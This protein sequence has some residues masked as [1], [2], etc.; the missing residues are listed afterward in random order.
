MNDNDRWARER[1][2]ECASGN[3]ETSELE[4]TDGRGRATRERERERHSSEDVVRQPM[5]HARKSSQKTSKA[6]FE[7][8]DDLGRALGSHDVFWARVARGGTTSEG[9]PLWYARGIEYWD[10]V[11]A[12]VEGVLGGFGRVSDVDARDN[13]TLLRATYGETLRA[14]AASGERATALDCGAGVGRVTSSFLIK[15]FDEVDLVEPVGHFLQ[16][17]RADENVTGA[18]RSDG[19]RAVGFFKVPLEEFVP[20]RARY[21]AIWIQW[22]V[23]HLTDDDLV[24][25]LKR[26]GDGLKPGGII[27][28]KENNAKE[29]F[30]LDLEDSS[31][32][33]SHEY[34][35]YIINKAGM[36]V[37]E[38]RYQT[39]FP[40]ELYPV[41]MYVFQP[42]L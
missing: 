38:H 9:K 41:S 20:E 37:V 42:R 29:G 6:T 16:A 31:I 24:A 21:D 3:E 27:V 14:R 28:L 23:G 32:T 40:V 13:G 12:N 17:A 26:C 33:R 8:R 15:Y 2:R 30:I 35:L 19:H 25:F 34:F 39:G 1:A 4:T 7:G 10:A 11:D 5:A 36:K 18:K 22:C